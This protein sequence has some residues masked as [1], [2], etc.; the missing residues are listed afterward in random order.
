MNKVSKI[1]L[2]LNLYEEYAI[3]QSY[4]AFKLVVDNIDIEQVDQIEY[5]YMAQGYKIFY[6]DL[7]RKQQSNTFQLTMIIAKLAYTF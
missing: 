1:P 5:D 4:S 2:D 3:H 6:T 7:V